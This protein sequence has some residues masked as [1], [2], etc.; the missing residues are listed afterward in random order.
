MSNDKAWQERMKTASASDIAMEMAEVRRAM[1][2]SEKKR[3]GTNGPT[4]EQK[5][6]YAAEVRALNSK[7]NFLRR[8]YKTA[9]VR[10]NEAYSRKEV[11]P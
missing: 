9:L 6:A 1:P 5:T 10:D 2:S 7:M 11:K 8:T 4:P 3:F